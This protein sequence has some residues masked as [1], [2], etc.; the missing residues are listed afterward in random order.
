MGIHTGQASEASTGMVDSEVLFEPA[1]NRFCH[2][3]AD[4]RSTGG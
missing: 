3:M 4:I 2:K 1:S